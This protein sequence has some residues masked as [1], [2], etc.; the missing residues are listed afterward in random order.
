MSQK[1]CLRKHLKRTLNS[2]HQKILT[3]DFTR[4]II[5]TF[6]CMSS[7]ILIMLLNKY[8]LIDIVLNV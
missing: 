7:K 5:L 2:F 4:L 8:Q 6:F 1:K 3:D